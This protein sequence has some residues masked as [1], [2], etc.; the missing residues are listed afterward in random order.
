MVL[1]TP[2]RVAGLDTPRSLPRRVTKAGP[3]PLR[4]LSDSQL[5]FPFAQSVDG[6]RCTTVLDRSTFTD[7]RG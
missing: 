7:A 5:T 6:Y 2:A 3:I 1:A 4:L